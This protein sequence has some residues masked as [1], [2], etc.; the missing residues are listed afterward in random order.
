MPAAGVPVARVRSVA[1]NPLTPSQPSF[2]C[3]TEPTLTGASGLPPGAGADGATHVPAN[4]ESANAPRARP[5]IVATREINDDF[6]M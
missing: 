3:V 1:T 4:A 5:P 6:I 2:V